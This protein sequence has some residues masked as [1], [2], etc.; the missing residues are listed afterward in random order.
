MTFSDSLTYV[1]RWLWREWIF[2]QAGGTGPVN[3]L[4]ESLH[5]V[6]IYAL[7]LAA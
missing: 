6:L 1:R 7:A 3:Q 4:P 2:P 5:K